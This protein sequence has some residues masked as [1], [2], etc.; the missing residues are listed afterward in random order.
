MKHLLIFLISFCAA[1][2]Q[3]EA[4]PQSFI[5]G[6][7]EENSAIDCDYNNTDDELNEVI[8]NVFAF[9][10]GFTNTNDYSGEIDLQTADCYVFPQNGDWC[11]GLSSD[12][13][14]PTSDALTIDLTSSLI[15]GQSYDLTF[16]VYGNLE[17]SNPIINVEVGES[18]NPDEF[19]VLIESIL[20]DPDSW[21]EVNL[22]FTASQASN[23]I[24]VRTA[25]GSDGWTQIDNFLISPTALSLEDNDLSVDLRLS[26]NPTS[27]FVNLDF[28]EYL[29][30]GSLTLYD[31]SG[32]ALHRQVIDSESSI[33][34]DVA[35]FPSGVYF[36]QIESEDSSG[37]V[38]FMKE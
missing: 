33:I 34:L 13:G 35:R 22:V 16:H 31:I 2:V 18:L 17:F 21:K 29:A 26:P 25:I 10:M 28:Q 19:G 37:M 12:S 38:K 23:H 30:S 5:N 11:L 27:T 1:L 36:I 8:S 15:P 7:F 32:Q 14:H 4:F 24:S 9:G 3:K 20:P 6:D